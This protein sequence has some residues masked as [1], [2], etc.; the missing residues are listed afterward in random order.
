MTLT[1]SHSTIDYLLDEANIHDTVTKMMLYVDLLRWDDIDKEVFTDNICVDYTGLLGGEATDV[2]RKEQIELW[3]RS[4][5]GLEKTQHITT[6]AFAPT[7]FPAI[8]RRNTDHS[9]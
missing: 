3:K 5:G 9:S 7:F 4:I 2:T 1:T 8:V 6:Y